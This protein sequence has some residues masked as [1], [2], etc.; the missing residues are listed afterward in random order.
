[1]EALCLQIGHLQDALQE[2]RESIKVSLQDAES[3]RQRYVAEAE[4]TAQA[5]KAVYQVSSVELCASTKG[6]P[7]HI[8]AFSCK[9]HCNTCVVRSIPVTR[10][11]VSA[12]CSAAAPKN[13][14]AY[15]Q[16]C[17]L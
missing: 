17:S 13:M 1:M 2:L 6:N 5:D 3:Q 9:E 4:A 7:N 12:V 10:C 8:L 15:C 14:P 16:H 11:A